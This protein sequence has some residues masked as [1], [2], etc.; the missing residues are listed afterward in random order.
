MSHLSET[1]VTGLPDT[2]LLQFGRV[3]D[4]GNSQL[5]ATIIR[6]HDFWR[7]V[8][9][10]TGRFA[11]SVYAINGVDA[12]TVLETI[13]NDTYGTATVG[14]LL[15]AGFTIRG[16]SINMPAY[17]PTAALQEW[18]FTVFLNAAGFEQPIRHDKA[19]SELLVTQLQPE[20][21]R[22]LSYFEPRRPNKFR[23]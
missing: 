16:T 2:L 19:T 22:L 13:R 11:I 10:S 3:D 5:L 7:G 15:R 21:D 18:H 9:D 23:I 14:Q 6:G 12:D 8:F 17:V 20:L 4:R 1:C